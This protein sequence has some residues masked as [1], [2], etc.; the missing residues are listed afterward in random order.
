MLAN[1]YPHSAARLAPWRPIPVGKDVDASDA[2]PG[3]ASRAPQRLSA[4]DGCESVHLSPGLRRRAKGSPASRYRDSTDAFIA[5]AG[6]ARLGALQAPILF[7]TAPCGALST[8][9]KALRHSALG[10][11]AASRSLRR[12]SPAAVTIAAA[13]AAEKVNVL[14]VGGGG[15]EHALCWRLRKSETC[16]DLYWCAPLPFRIAPLIAASSLLPWSAYPTA[17]GVGASP[18]SSGHTPPPR[19]PFIHSRVPLRPR[20]DCAV[21]AHKTRPRSAPGNAGISREAGVKTPALS[22]TD[23]AAVIK[24]CRDNRVGLVVIGPEAPLVD[25]ARPALAPPTQ[26]AAPR[27]RAQRAPRPVKPPSIPTRGARPLRLPQRR[28]RA[29][30]RPEQEGRPAGGLQGLHEIGRAHV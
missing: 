8:G 30:L 7:G 16:G 29:V 23:H 4:A 26:A 22:I 15:R 13:A 28:G 11:G 21:A 6:V 10:T 9:S 5:H 25:G 27:P 14:V 19:L 17:R 2:Q 12:R 3:G 1:L 20:S 24:F 18:L